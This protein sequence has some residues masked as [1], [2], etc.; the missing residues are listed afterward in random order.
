VSL[1]LLEDVPV[2]RARVQLPRWGA[3]WADVDLAEPEELTGRV[4]L[5]LAGQTLSGTVVS[6]G[7]VDG[8]AAY[9]VV[10][11][12]GGWGREV[13][14]QG[15]R[16][17]A[18]VRVLTVAT[19]AAQAVGETLADVPA[20]RLAG[21]FTR[22]RGPA[23]RV[24]HEVAPRSWH[25]G[26]DGV[27]RLAAWPESTYDGDAARVRVEPA[28]G[29]VEL[30]AEELEG[31]VPGV[32]VDGTRPA[33]DVEWELEP[34][35][36]TVRVYY[37]ARTTRR[38]DALARI[39]E[40][41]DPRRLYRGLAEYRV[42]AQLGERLL[43]QPVRVGAGLPDLDRVPVRPGMAG[44]RATVQLGSIVLV[45]WADSDPSRPCVVA[46]DAPDAPGWMPLHLDLGETPVLGV[47]RQTDAVQAGAFSGTITGGSVR[48]RAGL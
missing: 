30:A 23:S 17:D 37:S 10:A 14:P 46:H 6:G 43:L 41:L 35:R 44:L 26:L 4:T 38:I 9:R 8:R 13:T 1:A 42:V 28:V 3:W 36:L 20:T 34:E 12:A 29:L 48:V 45:A 24:L 33:S 27:T 21:H 18:G 47:A 31:L 7:A 39:V 32:V 19:E 40:A 16:S 11:G 25:V 15:Y 2:T 5:T 22:R